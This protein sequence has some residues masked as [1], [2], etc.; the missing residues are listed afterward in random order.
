M[1][2]SLAKGNA[3]NRIF[4]SIK[5]LASY[6]RDHLVTIQQDNATL[7]AGKRNLEHFAAVKHGRGRNI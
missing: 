4:S 5:R 6:M 2:N 3:F 1:C 7:Y